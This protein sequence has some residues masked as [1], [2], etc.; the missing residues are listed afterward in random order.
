MAL[1]GLSSSKGARIAGFGHATVDLEV[2][3]VV[4]RFTC[5]DSERLRELVESGRCVL[6]DG[7]RTF[8]MLAPRG[9]LVVL[10][11]DDGVTISPRPTV[12]PAVVLLEE[13]AALCSPT[14]GG[15]W[16]LFGV[17]STE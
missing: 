1:E 14:D 6:S 12:N 5:M 2:D 9:V 10:A 8:G 15:S 13:G 3:G 4:S 7:S 17:A 11:A 16:Q